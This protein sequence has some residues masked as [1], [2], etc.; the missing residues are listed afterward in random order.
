MSPPSFGDDRFLSIEDF[1][2]IASVSQHM[3]ARGAG[4]FTRLH[5]RSNS[6]S[7]RPLASSRL[8]PDALS[9]SGAIGFGNRNAGTVRHDRDRFA[10][11]LG[12]S[13]ESA[14]RNPP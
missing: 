10:S 12:Q 11:I 2:R 5:L 6:S 8:H 7:T 9:Q 14:E 3:R 1:A 4:R 13:N